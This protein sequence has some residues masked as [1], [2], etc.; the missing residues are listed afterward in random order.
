M[1]NTV[2]LKT[3]DKSLD[4]AKGLLILIVIFHHI[5]FAG[6]EFEVGDG[7]KKNFVLLPLYCSWFMPAFFVITGH[8]SNFD[9]P[10]KQ[11]LIINLKTIFWPALTGF[12]IAIGFRSMVEGSIE[13]FFSE[14]RRISI[15]GFNW[16]LTSMFCARLL[17]WAVNRYILQWSRRFLLLLMIAAFAIYANDINLFGDNWIHYR[18]TLYLS[19]FLCLGHH[20]KQKEYYKTKKLLPFAGLF[21]VLELLFMKTIGELPGI[22]GIW[23]NFPIWKMP[24]HLLLAITGTCFILLIANRLKCI[25]ILQYIGRNS[26]IYYLFHVEVIRILVAPIAL[27]VKPVTILNVIMYD[28][29]IVILSTFICT[30]ISILFNTK[31]GNLIVR[32]P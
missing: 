7:I 28:S 6:N 26:I 25:F 10:F 5:V 16:F 24:L 17:Y 4:V 22:A 9:K 32:L 21:I 13:V 18:H 15:L 3:R 27:V 2:K 8:C 1:S 30:M 19:F 20:A 12:I 31:Y 11:F 29:V 14:W 23:I